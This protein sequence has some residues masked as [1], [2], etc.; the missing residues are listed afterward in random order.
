MLVMMLL[1][2]VLANGAVLGLLLWEIRKNRSE[3]KGWMEEKA[4]VKFVV[5][6]SIMIFIAVGLTVFVYSFYRENTFFFT[7]KRAVLLALLWP[8]A[9]TDYFTFRIPNLFIIGG[10]GGRAAVL[11]AEI[12]FAREQLP[13][14]LLGE[15]VA[16]GVL[17]L[18]AGLCAV[19]VKNSIGGGDLKLFL[20]M[21]LYL[22][23]QGTWGA[24]FFSLLVSFVTAV[25][26]LVTG[27]ATRKDAIPFGPSLMIG[28]YLAIFLT[29]M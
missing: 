25:F 17:F 1:C 29:G 8:V 22:G 28:T 21:G 16:G 2:S 11:G 14:V 27:R 6:C 19:V 23:L 15:A 24:V 9:Y 20:V 10:L 4:R 13:R 5:Y 26:L 18:A 3:Y 7:L 12:V